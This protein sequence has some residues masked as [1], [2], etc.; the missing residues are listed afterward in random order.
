MNK[1]SKTEKRGSLRNTRLSD[2]QISFTDMYLKNIDNINI[3]YAVTKEIINC[4]YK[5]ISVELSKGLDF[6]ITSV[7][8]IALR[9]KKFHYKKR[10]YSNLVTVNNKV[11]HRQFYPIQFD[12]YY[13][14]P[15]VF[16]SML[17]GKSEEIYLAK[18][19][20]FNLQI[21]KSMNDEEGVNKYL[22]L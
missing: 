17:L 21:W 19:K 5:K 12:D 18:T 7:A 10:G 20:T 6:N 4:F 13:I 1:L 14:K 2:K 9:K 11:I 22:E 3:T 16:N 8:K 15:Y